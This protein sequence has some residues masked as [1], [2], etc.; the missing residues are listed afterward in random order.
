MGTEANLKSKS[1]GAIWTFF[2]FNLAVLVSVF[3]AENFNKIMNDV[4]SL[5]SVRTLIALIAPS[6]VFILNGLLS[7]N[8]KASI[9]FWRIKDALPGCRAFS[10]HGVL[11]YR[12]DMK[13]LQYLYGQLPVTPREQ[14][15]LW[16]KIFKK[17]REDVAIQKSHKDFLLA[18]DLT[19]ISFLFLV[20]LGIPFLIFG[21]YPFNLLYFFS[22]TIEYLIMVLIARNY[23]KRFVVN[24]LALESTT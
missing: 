11:D 3:F 5:I 22:V 24:V 8:Q 15:V 23:G 13:N 6:I 1:I 2:L 17:H 4:N 9:I 16:Y 7:S 14:N 12:V 20:L 21:S 18:R 10:K 19:S